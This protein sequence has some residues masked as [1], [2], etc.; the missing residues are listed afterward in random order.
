M[1]LR[2]VKR[3]FRSF[4]GGGGPNAVVE[5]VVTG[6]VLMSSVVVPRSMHYTGPLVSKAVVPR[7]LVILQVA[8]VLSAHV[9]PAF[10]VL[11]N[12]FVVVMSGSEHYVQQDGQISDLSDVRP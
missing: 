8:R 6:V 2:A 4:L 1:R 9:L 5:G 7:A 12:I 3:P 11:I 10:I